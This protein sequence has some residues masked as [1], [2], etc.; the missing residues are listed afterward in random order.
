MSGNLTVRGLQQ[1]IR[2]F[3][4]QPEK[5]NDYFLKLI[6]E[7]GE[8]A[9]VLRKD[10]R[11][12]Q[13]GNIKGTVEEELYDILYYVSALANIYE[14]DLEQCYELKEALNREKYKKMSN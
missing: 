10:V 7:V 3:D 11:L 8:L 4:H 12:N 1:Y 2:S 6:E 9:D 13:T 14:V 5:K